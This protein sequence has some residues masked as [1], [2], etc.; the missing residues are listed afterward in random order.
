MEHARQRLRLMQ[1]SSSSLPVGSFTW[2]QGLE[3]AVE[4]G[5]VT[6]AEAFRRWQIQQMEQS[7]FCVDLPLFIRLY[8]ACEKQDVA[9]AKRWTAYLLACRETRELRDEERNRG[10]AFTR[11]IKSWEPACPPEWLPLLMRSQL[12]GMAWLGVRWGI[13]ARE[14]ALSLGYS[15]IES[16]VMAGVK[17]VPFG[18]QAAQQLIIDL[19]DH[20]AAGFEQAFL[21]GDDALGA[22]TPLS[23]IASARHETQ[24]SRLFRS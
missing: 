13:N 2:S 18:Q 23:A 20:F 3:W 14:L 15:W 17:L 12:G 19:S 1:L 21:R 11:L 9:T 8:R 24:Y 10:A 16:A 7:F 6:D 22:A 5:W 4:A